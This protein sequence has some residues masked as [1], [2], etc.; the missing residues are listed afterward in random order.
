MNK[1]KI[2][3]LG[4]NSDIAIG[5]VKIYVNKGYKVYCGSRNILTLKE[6]LK[7]KNIIINE[8]I[9]LFKFDI[10]SYEDDVN[11]LIK[12]N[13]FESFIIFSGI[14]K[15]DDRNPEDINNVINTNFTKIVMLINYLA[16]SDLYNQKF[17][18]AIISSI[19]GEKIRKKNFLYSIT[20]QSLTQYLEMI[21]LNNYYKN[22]NIIII[23]PGYVKTKMTD[24]LRLPS[25]LT[26]SPKEI[27]NLIY[28]CI[29]NKKKIG[30]P[31]KWRV[32]LF[33]ISFIPSI[34]FKRLNI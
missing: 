14:F 27:G 23:K 6:N 34:I 26:N 17:N 29:K 2:V 28:N 1:K 33:V 25:I 18:V 21:D 4:A 16:N 11:K 31:W 20:K 24:H 3:L 32:V 8:N 12:K 5:T 7:N 15:F 10:N 9:E 13:F 22:M 30:I 19:A